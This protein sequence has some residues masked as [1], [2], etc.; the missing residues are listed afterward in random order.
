MKNALRD[1]I[2]TFA[3]GFLIS[4]LWMAI[5]DY[6][7]GGFSR[8]DIDFFTSGMILGISMLATINLTAR[9]LTNL[10]NNNNEPS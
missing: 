7:M 5:T 1:I 10:R 9:A 4:I 3:I 2:L 6:F 8:R